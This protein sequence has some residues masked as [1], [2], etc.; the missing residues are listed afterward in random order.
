MQLFFQ[1]PNSH[2]LQIQQH[3]LKNLT[4]LY[5]KQHQSHLDTG[6]P[7]K[8]PCLRKLLHLVEDHPQ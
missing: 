6:T 7:L 2:L 8:M 5:L 4:R 3:S 1:L